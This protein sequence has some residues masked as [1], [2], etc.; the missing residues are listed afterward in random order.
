MSLIFDNFPSREEAE[1]FIAEIERD[2]SLLGLKGRVFDDQESAD[3][4]DSF[5]FLLEPFIVHID[6]PQLASCDGIPADKIADVSIHDVLDD[7]DFQVT[8]RIE[9]AIIERVTQYHGRFAGT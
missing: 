2:F 4:D 6:R 1:A 8:I 3:K 5:P 7:R 9:N